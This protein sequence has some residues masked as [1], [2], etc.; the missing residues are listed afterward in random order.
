M[1][2]QPLPLTT[3]GAAHVNVVIA[4]LE[5]RNWVVSVRLGFKI[6]VMM[7][8]SYENNYVMVVSGSF[9]M[10]I[11]MVIMRGKELCKEEKYIYLE[12]AN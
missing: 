4:G 10:M 5:P 1:L 8:E 6:V 2:Q 11:K 12:R 7:L 9:K 3:R